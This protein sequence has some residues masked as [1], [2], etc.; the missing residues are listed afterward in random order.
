LAWFLKIETKFGQNK[1][2]PAQLKRWKMKTTALW[3]WLLFN[4]YAV[5][6][7]LSTPILPSDT[8]KE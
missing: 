4:S 8:L 5:I 7:V 3:L 1:S 6:C 2:V